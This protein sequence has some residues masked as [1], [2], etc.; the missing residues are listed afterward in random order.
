VY[1]SSGEY[2]MWTLLPIYNTGCVR[3]HSLQASSIWRKFCHFRLFASFMI[4]EKS[5]FEVIFTRKPHRERVTNCITWLHHVQSEVTG[6][7]VFSNLFHAFEVLMPIFNQK[8]Y[9]MQF[10]IL[11]LWSSLIFTFFFV[12]FWDTNSHVYLDFIAMAFF[13]SKYNINT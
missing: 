10:V 2:E 3:Y 8:N 1:I 11:S 6:W 4:F 5:R 7:L 13:S 9:M 12:L